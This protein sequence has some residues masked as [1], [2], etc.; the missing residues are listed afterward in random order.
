M[1]LSR[2]SKRN[3][4]IQA[5]MTVFSR[6]GFRQTTVEDIIQEAG[7]ARAT[8]YHYFKSKKDIFLELAGNIVDSIY[9]IAQEQFADYPDTVEELR[10]RLERAFLLSFDYF[11]INRDF[12]SIYFSEVIGM[13][14]ELDSKVVSFQSRLTE[15]LTAFLKKGH[16]KGL[17]GD[18]D[19]DLA[20]MV[21]SFAPQNIAIL[22]MMQGRK[23]EPKD[24][25]RALT[26]LFINGILAEGATKR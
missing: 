21:I 18:L 22:W 12:A 1:Q 8:F 6:R 26:D 13:N 11:G 20:S 16:E 25:A 4:V 17:V 3:A 5:A 7:V 23:G 9:A 19:F 2:S 24:L 14:P 10:Q 15:L